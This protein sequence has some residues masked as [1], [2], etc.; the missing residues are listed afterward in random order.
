[1]SKIYQEVSKVLGKMLKCR[2]NHLPLTSQFVLTPVSVQPH[3][4]V[5]NVQLPERKTFYPKQNACFAMCPAG[6]VHKCL[7]SVSLSA[8]KLTEV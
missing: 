5:L 1:M 4:P 2:N 7:Q 8:C 3:S 6:F